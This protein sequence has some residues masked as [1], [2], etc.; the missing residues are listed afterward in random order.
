MIKIVLYNNN[1]QKDIEAMVAQ[2]DLEFTESIFAPPDGQSPMPDA[3]WVALSGNE[4]V[5]TVAVMI[6]TE[7]ACILKKMMLKRNY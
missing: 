7:R 5:G 3:Y 1:Y 2:I 6:V 4:V